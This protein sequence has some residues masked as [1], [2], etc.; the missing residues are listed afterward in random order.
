MCLSF[1]S[2]GADFVMINYDSFS[3]IWYWFILVGTW[4]IFVQFYFGISFQQIKQGRQVSQSQQ[5]LIMR[6]I[7]LYVMRSKG[8]YSELAHPVFLGALCFIAA[9]WLTAAFFHGIEWM[10]AVS[11]IVFPL[12]PNIYQRA[13][14]S[15]TWQDRFPEDFELLYR[16]IRRLRLWALLFSTITIFLAA[17]WAMIL[18]IKQYQFLG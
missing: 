13:R 9:F 5:I 1:W 17:F 4:A 6:S 3:N 7:Q 14:L 15:M 18:W 10:Q 8:A 12:I 2:S 11:F 16:S